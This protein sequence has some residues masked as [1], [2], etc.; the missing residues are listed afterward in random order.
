MRARWLLLVGAITALSVATIHSS[1]PA[2][3]LAAG[4]FVVFLTTA[5]GVLLTLLRPHQGGGLT[6]LGHAIGLMALGVALLA[7]TLV[8][9][10]HREGHSVACTLGSGPC[11]DNDAV[12]LASVLI[13]IAAVL[14][15]LGLLIAG[16]RHLVGALR[17]RGG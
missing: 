16:L 6:R 5:F 13:L 4:L 14:G 7:A 1:K 15:L 9:G 12:V 2:N 17:A 11:G 8:G 3:V 10:A